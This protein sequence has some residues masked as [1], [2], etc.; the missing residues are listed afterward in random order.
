MTAHTFAIPIAFWRPFGNAIAFNIGSKEDFNLAPGCP[1]SVKTRRMLN[2]FW[3]TDYAGGEMREQKK[4][5]KNVCWAMWWWS[6][7]LV[8]VC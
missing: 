6:S 8:L 2:I 7:K 4:M 5:E 3:S 1:F